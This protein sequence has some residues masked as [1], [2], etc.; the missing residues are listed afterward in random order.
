MN[1]SFLM[2]LD[3]P[4]V[5]FGYGNFLKYSPPY[6]K[7]MEGVAL[8]GEGEGQHNTI[9]GLLSELGLVGAIPYCCIFYFFL[10]VSYQ[11]CR[12]TLR[13]NRVER[14]IAATQLALLVG[15]LV[16]MQ[17]SD[18]RF[19]N[20]VNYITFWMAGAVCFTAKPVKKA[21]K[22]ESREGAALNEPALA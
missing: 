12:G 20:I 3:R 4:I 9:L 8:R 19:F 5:G 17:C 10:K 7:E 6:F 11:K 2:F 16:Y 22:T 18:I 15:L 14:E 21:V 13:A 1:A